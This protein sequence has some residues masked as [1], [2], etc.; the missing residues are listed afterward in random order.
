MKVPLSWLREYV[1]TEAT[2]EQIARAL[3]I[4]TA[5]VNGVERRGVEG[6]L[7]LFR[8]GHVLEAEKHPNADRLQL[9]KV[10]VGEADPLQI[11]NQDLKRG[12]TG[13]AD[14]I[15]AELRD[16]VFRLPLPIQVNLPGLFAQ[17]EAPHD[18]PRIGRV[19]RVKAKE[20][21]G[22]AIPGQHIPSRPDNKGRMWTECV[23]HTLERGRDGLRFHYPLRWQF[24]PG[25]EKRW[26]LMGW[27]WKERRD[28]CITTIS[29]RSLSEKPDGSAE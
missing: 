16:Q 29:R 26:Y 25:L 18:I 24:L 21:I 12:I 19:R 14:I 15:G 28:L 4:S 1:H 27:K 11:V 2:A 22:D 23:H 9:T 3:S 10:D 8:V 20:Q 7:S 17:E 6:D 5:E 13:I